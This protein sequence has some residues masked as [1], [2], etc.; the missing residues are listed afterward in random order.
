VFR[1]VAAQLQ[2]TSSLGSKTSC[3][4]LPPVSSER[5]AHVIRFLEAASLAPADKSLVALRLDQL[6]R[7][8][9]SSLRFGQG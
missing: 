5:A 6:S 1:R 4:T 2:L 8:W 7:H 9:R 3:T